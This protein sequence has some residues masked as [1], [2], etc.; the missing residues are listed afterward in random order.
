MGEK[1]L[2]L[3]TCHSKQVEAHPQLATVAQKLIW[4]WHLIS[5]YT[6]AI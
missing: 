2:I 5:N 6:S 4:F 1:K 3:L